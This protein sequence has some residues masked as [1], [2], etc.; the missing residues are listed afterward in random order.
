MTDVPDVCHTSVIGSQFV[1][2][3]PGASTEFRCLFTP[4]RQIV[5]LAQPRP[6]GRLGPRTTVRLCS[7]HDDLMIGAITGQQIAIIADTRIPRNWAKDGERA[8]AGS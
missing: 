4:I 2:W 5:L 1:L 8:T 3:R 6:D 7:V